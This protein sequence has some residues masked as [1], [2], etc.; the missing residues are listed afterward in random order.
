MSEKKRVLLVE[1]NTLAAKVATT[2]LARFDCETDVAPDAITALEYFSRHGYDF[3]L[4]DI[5]LP[6]MGGY[7]FAEVI[8]V[9]EHQTGKRIPIFSL[10]A[11]AVPIADSEVNV[12]KGEKDFKSAI[13]AAF[14]KPLE[15]HHVTHMLDNYVSMP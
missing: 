10:T 13:D 8:R 12:L 9:M 1:D 3:I 4:T 15:D 11:K 2:I 5:A 6:D 14:V 7:V